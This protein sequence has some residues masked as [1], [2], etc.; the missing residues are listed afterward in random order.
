[1]LQNLASVG[2]VLDERARLRAAMHLEQ[3]RWAMG[4]TSK[5]ELCGNCHP[6]NE[7]AVSRLSLEIRDAHCPGAGAML[8]GT[9][10]NIGRLIDA[11]DDPDISD[12]RMKRLDDVAL[13]I[14]RSVAEAR[15]LALAAFV[16]HCQLSSGE[17]A[18]D[19][20][21]RRV[22][23][24][25]YPADPAPP[26]SART[27]LLDSGLLMRPFAVERIMQ[28][29]G[30]P[31]CDAWRP[32]VTLPD[33]AK[34]TVIGGDAGSG[35]TF[36]ALSH[37]V[38][39][40]AARFYITP[41][42]GANWEARVV[43]A[44]QRS[45]R[46]DES[47]DEE[48]HRIVKENVMR[49]FTESMRDAVASD[50]LQRSWAGEWWNDAFIGRNEAPIRIIIDDVGAMPNFLRGLAN[51]ADSIIAR[52][53]GNMNPRDDCPADGIRHGDIIAVG[54]GAELAFDGLRHK[55]EMIVM[56]NTTTTTTT[57]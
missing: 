17:F 33:E 23:M 53:A 11:V 9:T 42:P 28:R 39:S 2:I 45:Y 5:L 16:R 51:N 13:P 1:M 6:G 25:V 54:T 50:R 12:E 43:A 47:R 57:A 30:A 20:A 55:P 34:F 22:S 27:F 4:Y 29:F 26:E 8:L 32:R 40:V 3:A 10:A 18:A 36:A 21:Q 46:K 52:L 19:P 49:C 56:K 44:M 15:E 38:D 7:P 37:D 35:K 41:P 14:L 31:E 48:V 24:T